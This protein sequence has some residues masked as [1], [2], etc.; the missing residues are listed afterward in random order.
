MVSLLHALC[1][2]DFLFGILQDLLIGFILD[3]ATHNISVI[4][5]IWAPIVL[6]SASGKGEEKRL[7]DHYAL[8]VSWL[9]IMASS[10]HA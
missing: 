9:H 2:H 5:A 10:L 3:V 6:V 8:P 7:I 4:I 1:D